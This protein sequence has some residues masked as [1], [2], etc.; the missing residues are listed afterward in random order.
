VLIDIV[1]REEKIKEFIS[2]GEG[3]GKL[4]FLTPDNIGRKRNAL[5][6]SNFLRFGAL[7]QTKAR[8]VWL[9]LA[10]PV[11]AE[12]WWRRGCAAAAAAP[13]AAQLGPAAAQTPTAAAHTGP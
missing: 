10:R 12:A 8:I 9:K 3:G 2:Q 11:L 7:S 4:C 1:S 5:L 6:A 13:P